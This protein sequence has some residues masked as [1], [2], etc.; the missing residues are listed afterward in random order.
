MWISLD[1][2]L[3]KIMLK[4][5]KQWER[6]LLSQVRPLLDDERLR[7]ATA[8]RTLASAHLTQ[9]EDA[10]F[11]YLERLGTLEA[12]VAAA[13]EEFA[14]L[15]ELKAMVLRARRPGMRLRGHKAPPTDLSP[16]RLPTLL[17][18]LEA[19]DPPAYAVT[20][21]YFPE[22]VTALAALLEAALQQVFAQWQALALETRTAVLRVLHTVRVGLVQEESRYLV[23]LRSVVET[24]HQFEAMPEVLRASRD[25]LLAGKVDV[26]PESPFR[27]NAMAVVSA[28]LADMIANP[29]P[30]SGAA[31]ARPV[32]APDLGPGL[33]PTPPTD[34]PSTDQPSTDQPAPDQPPSGERPTDEP[35][36]SPDAPPAPP[37]TK[38]P[39]KE[40]MP[41]PMPGPALPTQP[42]VLP[43]RP[44]AQ[45]VE[46][47][48]YTDVRFPQQVRAQE[49]AALVVRLTR[50]PFALSRAQEQVSVEFG[51]PDQ[52][53]YVEVVLVAHGFS[54]E[55]SSYSRTLAVYSDR[56][57]Q[58]AVFQLRADSE[59]GEYRITLDFYHK[60]R[61][62]G[63]AA[64]KTRIVE[65][66][67]KH[68]GGVAVEMPALRAQFVDQPPPPA[69]L[70]LRITRGAQEN[71]LQFTLHSARGAVGYHWKPVGQVRLN[72]ESA[73]QY[74][75]TLFA[76][77]GE[78]AAQ[79]VDHLSEQD[80]RISSQ[81][82]D[83]IGRQ[84]YRELF[85]PELQH[86]LWTRIL[87]RRRSADNP[88]GVIA[89]LLITSDEPWIPWE[90]VK[91]YRSDPG[92]GQEQRAGFLAETFQ[93]AR[94]LAGRS[95]A[96][97]L[98]VRQAGIVT[99][100]QDLTYAQR[101][102]AYFRQWAARRVE[103][104]GPLRST[105]EVRQLAA[106][107]DVQL[108]HVAAHGRFDGSNADLSPLALQ[109][110]RLTPLDLIGERGAALRKQRP[111]V[112][113]NACHTARLAFALTGLGG[114][115]ERLVVDL[116][117]SV[118]V[119]TLWEVND[120]LAAEF[121]IAFYDRLFAGDT[122][123]QAFYA[124]RLH[125]RDRQP[126]NP[127]WLAYVLY[128]DPNSVIAWGAEAQAEEPAPAEESRSLP[129]EPEEPP[130]PPVDPAQL[131]EQLEDAL[132]DALPAA[133]MAT[134]PE[135][136]ARALARL[137]GQ[138][139]PADTASADTAPDGDAPDGDAPAGDAPAA[140]GDQPAD[141]P[142]QGGMDAAALLFLRALASSP[143][144]EAAPPAAGSGPADDTPARDAD[145]SQDADSP[146]QPQG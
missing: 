54:E 19:V 111:L 42:T 139:P 120:L 68:V 38:E 62:L 50:A 44:P 93:V 110:G 8:L 109:D 2:L 116:G 30:V 81:D 131:A 53:E 143:R 37:P 65:K 11:L 126:A 16:S 24:L 27:Y 128:G 47:D 82:I 127:T 119:G 129:P 137:L 115:A 85:P 67:P 10:M 18:M 23:T 32:P 13:A 88:D 28:G 70:E 144:A 20:R 21:M 39:V 56:D 91:P 106:A 73:Q 15:P 52:P 95:P 55:S 133:I 96:H 25:A 114:W 12:V 51:Q 123:G 45:V 135:V 49:L 29:P 76:H 108:W 102:E 89:S 146:T 46:R 141:G 26:A 136:V 41:E 48:F 79:S 58:A 3:E 4:L 60:G 100:P 5:Y 75:Q 122:L 77:L 69:D 113:L 117:V 84:L 107:G 1:E 63:S 101:E 57:S 22:D 34:Q 90:M 17:A 74:L 61:Y 33:E 71:V 145:R 59:L 87:P 104:A 105:S 92:S 142:T 103:V 9:S 138:E 130:A 98:H 112:F 31:P 121:A 83:A 124:A 66:T 86:E 134:V 7:L 80:A 14:L 72:S 78:P 40:P 35:G 125:V 99:P 6:R 132:I 118:F 97:H 43:A 140:N 64:F 36:E 94:W